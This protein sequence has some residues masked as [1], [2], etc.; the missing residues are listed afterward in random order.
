MDGLPTYSLR[1][2]QDRILTHKSA[3]I[4]FQQR[5]T[6]TIPLHTCIKWKSKL[7]DSITFL[8]PLTIVMQY[9]DPPQ[10]L[11]LI[12]LKQL[13][14]N[15]MTTCNIAYNQFLYLSIPLRELKEVHFEAQIK[16]SFKFQ[17]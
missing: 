8:T 11:S 4:Y 7:N 16:F 5:C 13:S 15:N 14:P 12:I 1:E 2:E 17:F 9:T 6:A 10:I 3:A